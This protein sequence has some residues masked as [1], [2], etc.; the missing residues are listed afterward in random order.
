VSDGPREQSVRQEICPYKTLYERFLLN[1]LSGRETELAG[2]Q[3]AVTISSNHLRIEPDKR[4]AK[5]IHFHDDTIV[6]YKA[7]ARELT[8]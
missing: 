8:K 6:F 5:K 3:T 4:F 1:V 2:A 7:W